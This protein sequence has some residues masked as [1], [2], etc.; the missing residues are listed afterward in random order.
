[1]SEKKV[2]VVSGKQFSGKDTVA[3]VLKDVLSG[4]TV[5]P[6]AY[7]IKD[8]F[9]KEKNLTIKEVD[10]NK[11]IYRADL[12]LLGSRRRDE[13]P[14]YWIKKVLEYEGNLIVPD[15]RLKRELKT[16][17]EFNT[18]TIRVKSSREERAKRG[19]LV[20]EHDFTE[21]ALDEVKDW[22]YVIE[23]NKDIDTLKAIAKEIAED[24]KEKL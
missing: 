10:M 14:D 15:V 2:I 7:A 16:F 1:M 22:D 19:K 5:A 4:F 9:S 24:I 18:I 17:K 6:I 20:S 12:I 23:N 8:E 21:V 13:D 11:P 3:A